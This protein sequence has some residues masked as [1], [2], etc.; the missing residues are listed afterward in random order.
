[1]KKSVTVSKVFEL[2]YDRD[3][4]EFKQA[5]ES[6]KD[7]INSGAN[8]DDILKQIA[9]TLDRV[10]AFDISTILIEGV[11]RVS[12]KG[13]ASLPDLWCGVEVQDSDPDVEVDI[14]G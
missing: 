9:F 11:G 3:S 7:S 13:Q 12:V 5:L 8:A 4:L 14:N 1:L 6:Y 10:S 2:V